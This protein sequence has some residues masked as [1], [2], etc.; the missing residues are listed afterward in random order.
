MI[1]TWPEI[2]SRYQQQCQDT[3]SPLIGQYQVTWHQSWLLIGPDVCQGSKKDWDYNQVGQG[4]PEASSTEIQT[5]FYRLTISFLPDSRLLQHNMINAY[6]ELFTP[7]LYSWHL[8]SD[9]KLNF[10]ISHDCLQVNIY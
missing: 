3:S 7:S 2:L 1:P 9:T 8:S 5:N 4:G 6:F 10:L